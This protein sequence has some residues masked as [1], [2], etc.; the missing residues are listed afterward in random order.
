MKKYTFLVLL[1][2]I[3]NSVF[4]QHNHPLDTVP[5]PAT[6]F[7]NFPPVKLL[8]TDSINYFT[9]EMLQKNKPVF[10]MVFH[11]SCEHCQHEAEDITRNIDRFKGIQIVM[12]S[13]ASL[14]E[15]KPFIDKYKLT[16]YDNIIVAQDYSFF[17]PPFFQFNNLPFLAFYNKKKKLVST[18]GGSLSVDKILAE[19]RK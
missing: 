13:M 9:K 10:L 7:K 12:S 16:S 15:M 1:L 14:S 4:T 11:P 17:L 19:L 5:A 18:F 2:I 3:S 6:R 8:L